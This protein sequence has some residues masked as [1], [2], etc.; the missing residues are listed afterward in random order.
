[1]DP[2][3]L[4]PFLRRCGGSTEEEVEKQER[5]ILPVTELLTLL[6]TE[7]RDAPTGSCTKRKIASKWRCLTLPSK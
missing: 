6:M 5:D 1:M 4:L 2:I 7:D 3:M